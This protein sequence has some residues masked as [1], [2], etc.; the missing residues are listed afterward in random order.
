MRSSINW[1]YKW[2]GYQNTLATLPYHPLCLWYFIETSS[3]ELCAREK[4]LKMTE[5]FFIE[6]CFCIYTSFDIIANRMKCAKFVF[7]TDC[8][9]RGFE[10]ITSNWYFSRINKLYK[11]GDPSFFLI[12]DFNKKHRFC[13]E[14]GDVNQKIWLSNQS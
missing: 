10:I 13:F 4:H 2:K 8:Y 12:I 6:S 1:F 7:V 5:W 3:S 9:Q 14:P 11:V